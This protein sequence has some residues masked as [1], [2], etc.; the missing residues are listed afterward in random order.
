M[1]MRHHDCSR[2]GECLTRAA[3]ANTTFDCH[4]C[5]EYHPTVPH[6][7]MTDLAGSLRL[8]LALFYQGVPELGTIPSETILR[9][10]FDLRSPESLKIV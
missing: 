7:R 4:G 5:P 10:W 6:Y 8:Y 9:H 2:Y 3:R 1:N